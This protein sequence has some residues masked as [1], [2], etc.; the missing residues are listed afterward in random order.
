MKNENE[1]F[2]IRNFGNIDGAHRSD[3]LHELQNESKNRQ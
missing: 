3:K 1:N 2:P